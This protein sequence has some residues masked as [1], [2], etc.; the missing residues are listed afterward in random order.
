M[1]AATAGPLRG[2]GHLV[3]CGVLAD[4]L[5]V[6]RV[7]VLRRTSPDTARAVRRLGW[8]PR[9]WSDALRFRLPELL[10][11]DDPSAVET[12]RWIRRARRLGIPVATLHDGGSVAVDSDL[13]I[14]VGLVSRH[15]DTAHR[16]SGPG[17]A[18][19]R[20]SDRSWRPGTGPTAANVL[21]ALGGGVHVRRLGARVASAIARRLPDAEVRVAA[22]FAGPRLPRLPD[23]CRWIAPVDGLAPALAEASACVVSG[24][25]TLAEACAVGT[26]AVAVAVVAAQQPAVDVV[27]GSRAALTVTLDQLNASERLAELVREL[28]QRPALRR[29]LSRNARRLV[30]R[31]GTARVVRRLRQLIP[32]NQ[33]DALHAV[34]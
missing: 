29:E 24:G 30:D 15:E 16:V 18:V 26:P 19:L 10:I 9:R 20:A 23:R 22:G 31:R 4:A 2:F 5:G 6:P 13:V 33:G 11:V 27:V 21:V 17:F 32:R 7:I 12:G 1:F 14:D 3:R 34:A 8:T 25:V 28:L